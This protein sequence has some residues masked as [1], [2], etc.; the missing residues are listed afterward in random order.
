MRHHTALDWN[1]LHSIT[2]F[3]VEYLRSNL[4]RERTLLGLKEAKD[5]IE[6]CPTIVGAGLERSAAENFVNAMR[7]AGATANIK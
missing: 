6:A 3:S 4:V 5:L 1:R 7:E 2:S